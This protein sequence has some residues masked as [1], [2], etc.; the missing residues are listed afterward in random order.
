MNEPTNIADSQ[1]LVKLVGYFATPFALTV[2]G[3]GILVAEVEPIVQAV[4]LGLLGFSGFLNLVF[5]KFLESQSADKK[6]PNVRVRMALNIVVNALLVYFLGEGFPP[7]WLILTLSPFATA[8]Y[9]S[10]R[11]TGVS[12]AT[13]C[14]VLVTVQVLRPVQSLAAWAA[15]ATGIAFIALIAFMINGLAHLTD[16]PEK[17]V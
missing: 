6:G 9:G 5:P 13:S 14:V 8:I 1:K 15:V 7:I 12:A 17:L 3:L 11:K 4:C 16:R 10:R 2:G